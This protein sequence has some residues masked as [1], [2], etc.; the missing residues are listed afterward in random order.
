VLR[1]RF[2]VLYKDEVR[3]NVQDDK[4]GRLLLNTKEKSHKSCFVVI[5][6]TNKSDCI[7]ELLNNNEIA[8]KI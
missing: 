6:P 4:L 8:N 2:Y 3:V 5:S 1:S 7:I